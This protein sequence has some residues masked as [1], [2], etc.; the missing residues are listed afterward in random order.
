MLLGLVALLG[1]YAIPVRRN[2]KGII[3]GYGTLL[4]VS[5][6]P[7]NQTGLPGAANPQFLQYL[8]FITCIAA[9]VIWC[10]TLWRYTPAFQPDVDAR[11]NG[12]YPSMLAAIQRRLASARAYLRSTAK[13]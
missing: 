6:I 5:V 2:V 9:L 3:A 11:L 13:P 7:V 1:Y 10:S 4:A 12:D 8:Q